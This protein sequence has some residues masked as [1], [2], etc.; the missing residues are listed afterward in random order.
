MNVAYRNEGDVQP[1]DRDRGPVGV[2]AV[3]DTRV[4]SPKTT[5][6]FVQA[7]RFV[8]FIDR[9]NWLFPVVSLP[10]TAWRACLDYMAPRAATAGRGDTLPGQHRRLVAAINLPHEEPLGPAP[11][12]ASTPAI[13][14]QHE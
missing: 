5:T 14:N 7:M 1:A 13:S 12:P 2:V 9:D 4:A 10:P 8:L 3:T 6:A 11:K